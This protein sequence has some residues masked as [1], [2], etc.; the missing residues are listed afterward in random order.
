MMYYKNT[1]SQ[2]DNSGVHFMNNLMFWNVLKTVLM[3]DNN[4]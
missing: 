4:I 2:A 1:N 3:T